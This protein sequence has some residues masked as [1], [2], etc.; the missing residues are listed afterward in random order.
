MS[1]YYGT[2]LISRC[3]E[4]RHPSYKQTIWI[5]SDLPKLDLPKLKLTLIA[6]I[7]FINS[8]RF[9][10]NLKLLTTAKIFKRDLGTVLIY[11]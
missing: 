6:E 7:K 2:L 10:E 11:S 1:Q 4:P 8:I 9:T 3:I 5:R